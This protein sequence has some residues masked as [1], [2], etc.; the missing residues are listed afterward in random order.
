MIRRCLFPLLLLGACA[1]VPLI[2]G[3]TVVDNKVNRQL[4]EVCENYRRA[5]EARDSGTLL[6]LAS[7]H[8][9][10]D[11]GTPKT[12]DDYGYEGLKQVLLSRLS[13]VREI[14]YSIEYRKIQVKGT[15]AQIDVRY[16]ASYQMATAV[17][18]RWERKM[19][20]QRFQLEN[21]GNKWLFLSGM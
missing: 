8:Y 3:T 16:D 12:I 17:G 14:R 7:K 15:T 13:A 5:I 18:D 11:S 21:N 1:S 2:A 9:Y 6:S 4:I 10:E 20:D 19:S